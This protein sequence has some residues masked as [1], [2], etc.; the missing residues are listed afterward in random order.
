MIQNIDTEQK[1]VNA[2][3]FKEINV[4]YSDSGNGTIEGYAAT[5]IREP[6]SYDDVVAKGAFT[7]TLRDR[8]N[9]GKGIPFL[10]AHQMDDVDAYIGTATAEEDEKG[11]HFVATFDDTKDAQRI[12]QLYKDG[13][14]RK[15]SFAYNILDAGWV[16]L[17]NG[18]KAYELRDLE[19]YEISAVC[20]PANEDAGVLDVK[21]GWHERGNGV[22]KDEPED[23][24]AAED[25]TG[26]NSGLRARALAYINILERMD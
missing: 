11:L 7:R 6:D 16:T 4:D 24:A 23:K 1:G 21:N 3:R 8:Y 2:M 9:G 15:F 25:L 13:R 5:W 19:L 17:E 26:S 12:R 20:V 22:E 14:L 10:W 18:A